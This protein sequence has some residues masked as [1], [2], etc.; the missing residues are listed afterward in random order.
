VAAFRLTPIHTSDTKVTD[1]RI[2]RCD[3]VTSVGVFARETPKL[4]LP[5][6]IPITG[7]RP[8]NGLN[9]RRLTPRPSR[10]S[11]HRWRRL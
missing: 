1:S 3:S 11:P 9:H 4:E 2:G 6:S 7:G 5:K 8:F 10:F